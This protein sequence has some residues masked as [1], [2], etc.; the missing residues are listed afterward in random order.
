MKLITR[1]QVTEA[2]QEL[3]SLK[4]GT[5][6]K[7]IKTGLAMGLIDDA[8]A[9]EL[10]AACRMRLG[11]GAV[12]FWCEPCTTGQAITCP[13]CGADACARC[14]SCVTKGCGP[15]GVTSYEPNPV[16]LVPASSYTSGCAE[17]PVSAGS[18]WTEVTYESLSFTLGGRAHSWGPGT[19][20]LY[21]RP[22]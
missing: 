6:L 13:W 22:Q 21:W 17:T 11:G 19:A 7:A 16:A 15:D 9:G 4:P 20:Y 12:V 8:V 5:Q 18:G 2:L 10:M 1:K 3:A 14:W